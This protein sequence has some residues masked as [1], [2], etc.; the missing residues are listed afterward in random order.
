MNSSVV[1][2]K[3]NTSSCEIPSLLNISQSTF[4]GIITKWKRMGTTARQPQSIRP[5]K[6]TEQVQLKLRRMSTEVGNFS[7]SQT[8]QTSKLHAGLHIHA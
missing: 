2:G 8:L 4:S 5:R 6:I 1:L 7:Q 3:C